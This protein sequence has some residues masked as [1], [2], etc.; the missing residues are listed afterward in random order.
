MEVHKVKWISFSY[1]FYV[2]DMFV[3]KKCVTE[4]DFSLEKFIKEVPEQKCLKYTE[5]PKNPNKNMRLRGKN[6][7]NASYG[8]R[9]HNT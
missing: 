9:N 6:E 7:V 4:I 2:R 5:K 3:D 1:N 8:H